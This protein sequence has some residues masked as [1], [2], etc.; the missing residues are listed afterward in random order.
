MQTHAIFICSRWHPNVAGPAAYLR[1]TLPRILEALNGEVSIV[2][3]QR[4]GHLTPTPPSLPKGFFKSVR[5]W[6]FLPLGVGSELT[7]CRVAWMAWRHSQRTKMPVTLYF[8]GGHVGAG[9]RSAALLGK[10]LG[11][12]VVVECVLVGADDARVIKSARW[13]LLTAIATRRVAAFSVISSALR[14]SFTADM[15]EALVIYNPYGIDTTVF[16]PATRREKAFAREGLSI[17]NA[18]FVGV[19]VGNVN[20]RKDVLSLVAAWL[21]AARLAPSAR[22]TL[23][24][25][26]HDS[27]DVEYV[28][29]I[30]ALIA[31]SPHNAEVRL[32]GPR[33]D[34]PAIF[35]AADVYASASTAEGLGIA[36]LEA[37][38][39]GLPVICR[40]LPGITDDMQ[41]GL[42]VTGLRNWTPDNFADVVHRVFEL[43]QL[44]Q[45]RRDAEHVIHSRFELADRLNRI[46]AICNAP[47]ES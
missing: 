25:V 6:A 36:N 5:P 19:F 21:H 15:P 4:P 30:H 20:P 11:I 2:T 18:D 10:I 16:R 42:A 31:T 3:E 23:L 39:A 14:D 8:T 27:G 46:A 32:L 22:W 47:D 17:G 7:G 34:V 45:S 33:D 43:G 1:R 28:S 29:R 13:R 37:L 24:I 40:Y 35:R 44:A 9:W 26:G 41:H 38:A 12:R